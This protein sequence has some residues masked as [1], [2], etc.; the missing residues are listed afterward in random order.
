MARHNLCSNSPVLTDA[1]GG[2][3]GFS[4]QTHEL[5]DDDP[6]AVSWFAY[7]INEYNP[8][9]M[10][11]VGEEAKDYPDKRFDLPIRV[12]CFTEKYA[13]K[14]LDMFILGELS[15]LATSED[16][17]PPPPLPLVEE[18]YRRTE[19]GSG[20]RTFVVD[21]YAWW[22]KK[23]WYDLEEVHQGLLQCPKFAVDLLQAKAWGKTEKQ[24]GKSKY[25]FAATV[26][27][28]YSSHYTPPSPSM[29]RPSTRE[30]LS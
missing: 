25:P 4:R 22:A 11:K 2:T 12:L 3:D 1:I 24:N 23:K 17:P 30:S 14:G 26:G 18:V 16:R 15:K 7:W 8:G 10:F 27:F 21:W 19:D 20:V 6:V 28:F 29:F 9:P 5:P 13:V